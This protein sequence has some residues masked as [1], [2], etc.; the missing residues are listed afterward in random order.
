MAAV[1][2]GLLVG[3]L[4]FAHEII[5]ITT[6]ATW[7]STLSSIL[8]MSVQLK[9]TGT[10]TVTGHSVDWTDTTDATVVTID[11]GTTTESSVSV[12][13]FGT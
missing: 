4:K 8:G 10:L 1:K 6:Q 7:D 12:Y 9:G 5:N 3:G 11:L 2:T 13:A